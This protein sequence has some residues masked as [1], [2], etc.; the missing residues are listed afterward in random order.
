[1][2][3]MQDRD[4]GRESCTFQERFTAPYVLERKDCT[5]E[6]VQKPPELNGHKSDPLGTGSTVWPAAELLVELCPR[7]VKG[8]RVLELGSGTGLLGIV[9]AA[10]GA[11][12]V[13]LTDLPS[14]LT[15]LKA[16]VARNSFVQHYGCAVKVQPLVWNDTDLQ[17]FVQAGFDLVVCADVVYQQAHT[18][19]LLPTL[20]ELLR[21]CP[22]ARL[23]IAQERHEPV[24]WGTLKTGLR[25]AG[26]SSQEVVKSGG[27]IEVLLFYW[28]VDGSETAPAA[29]V[30]RESDT[31]P[32]AAKRRHAIA[33]GSSAF[34]DAVAAA[35]SVAS[36]DEV[37]PV[38]QDS[39]SEAVSE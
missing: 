22:D 31:A 19:A 30:K 23:L 12:A 15:L 20:V 25:K 11:S 35:L 36:L 13:T 16:N 5:I 9:A 29:G 6:I 2:F 38:S 27:R 21:G 39:S 26:L 8:K 7:H 24:A 3:D 1:V 33:P 28:P 4:S 32:P 17:P 18:E 14:I 34:T 37:E 10:S